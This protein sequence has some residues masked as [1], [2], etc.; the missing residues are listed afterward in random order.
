MTLV[1]MG[2]YFPRNGT[3]A[4]DPSSTPNHL[5]L[6]SKPRRPRG[7]PRR[8]QTPDSFHCSDGLLGRPS[9]T[10]RQRL[11]DVPRFPD[12]TGQLYSLPG[13][14]PGRP[15]GSAL[16]RRKR[17]RLP[18]RN[19]QHRPGPPTVIDADFLTPDDIQACRA[20]SSS[21]VFDAPD[22]FFALPWLAIF[23]EGGTTS[24]LSLDRN[25]YDSRA[26]L[27]YREQQHWLRHE[28][29]R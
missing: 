6:R 3:G 17:H 11:G 23:F 1:M 15:P 24:H 21:P 28:R 13:S 7:G 29:R 18:S 19:F 2:D 8:P 5:P 22:G 26:I 4:V 10:V 25:W 27:R 20:G 14:L 9:L 12:T 16:H